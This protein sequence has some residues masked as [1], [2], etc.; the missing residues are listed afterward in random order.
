M[1]AKRNVK[2]SPGGDSS[3][4]PKALALAVKSRAPV[5]ADHRGR[6]EEADQ[7][8]ACPAASS[9]AGKHPP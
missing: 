9:I 3:A 8:S 5:A 1:P 6:E 4:G 2:A 7:N